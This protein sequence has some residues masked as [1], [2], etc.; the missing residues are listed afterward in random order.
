MLSP[1]RRFAVRSVLG[2]VLPGSGDCYDPDMP[3]IG[4]Y[5]LQL[6]AN[7]GR[8]VVAAVYPFCRGPPDF[9]MDI[10]LCN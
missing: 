8:E 4:N 3:T 5:I 2:C 1:V 10:L 7:F 9:L 6:G